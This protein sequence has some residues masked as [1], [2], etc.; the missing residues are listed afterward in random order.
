VT[1][2]KLTGVLIAAAL[3]ALVAAPAMA[4]ANL[5]PHGSY[6]TD[7]DMCAQ[8]HRAHTAPS[9]VTWTD[10]QGDQRNALLLADSTETYQFCLA[11][12]DTAS[13]GAD[14]NVMGGVYEGS[15]YGT[16]NTKM[17]S[18]AFGSVNAGLGGAMYDTSGTAVTSSHLMDGGSWGAYGGG[19]KG[20]TSATIAIGGKGGN[21]TDT[22]G[23]GNLIVMT[24]TTCHDP[25]GSSNYR[26]LKD[27]VNSVPV[28]GYNEAGNPT[29]FVIS[30]EKNFP[31][32]GFAL[33]VA[34]SPA[35]EPNYTKAQY[36]KAPNNGD[37]TKGITGWCS[38]CH[39]TY[40]T[41]ASVYN[42]SDV[43]PDQVSSQFVTRHRHPV[44][45]E[46]NTYYVDTLKH[47]T[48]DTVLPLAHDTSEKGD[49]ANT[50]SD[51]IDCLTCHNAHGSTATMTGWSDLASST[52][53]AVV[54]SRGNMPT[55]SNL[56]KMNNRGVCE[57]CHNK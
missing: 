24:C 52:V 46:L 39:T 28:G 57:A 15:A 38:G 9:S 44:N 20:E 10:L 55:D 4:F 22:L 29:P 37:I 31:Q 45:V 16:P 5:G 12:H 32:T 54:G 47:L 14:T 3:V 35:Y 40:N 19:L 8:C 23:T 27:S 1:M 43:F 41:T 36:A 2:K 42:A 6:A 7:T 11:C 25:H 56:L 50:E 53:K 26:L 33:H 51:W 48:T 17:I 49:V 13:Q 18:G 21:Y 30:N 34:P